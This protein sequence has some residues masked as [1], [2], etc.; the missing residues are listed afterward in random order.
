[1]TQRRILVTAALPYA[2]GDI[3]IGHLVEYIQTDIWV[4]FQ[5]LRG[6]AC[7]FFCADDTHGTAIMIR[8]RQEGRS[9]ETLIADVQQKHIADFAGF[10][11]EFDH[12]GSTNS[13]QN[14]KLCYEIWEALRKADLVVEKEV[15]QLFDVQENT[16]LA[17]RFVK[18]TCPKCKAPDQYGDN[19]D[20]CGST[21][22]PADLA[23]PISTLSNTTPE[24]RTASHLFVRIEDLHGFLDEWTQSG[25]HL[26]S[27]VANYLKGHFLGDPLRDW[28]ISRPAPYFGFEI[29]DSPGNYWYVWFDAP[30]G[31]IASTLEWC[32]NN[33]EDFDQWWKN[34]ETEVHHF[35][36]KDITYF[37]TLF[38]PAM[39]KTAGF[40][41]PEKVHI[42]GFL[43]VDGEKMSK[44]KG[45]FVKASTYLNHLDPACLR[46][47]YASKLGPRLD[48]LDLNLD[49][50]IQ[51]V[52]SDLVG[53]VVNLASRSA[54]FV[55]NTGL[56]AAYP[57]DGGL[58]AHAASRSDAIAA[59][60]EA[61]DYNG[62]MR[63]IL[64]L[65]DRANK[66]V[67]DQKPWELRQDESRQAEL[68]NICSISLNLFRQIVIYLSPVLPKLSELTGELL[69][70][71]IT[72]WDQAQTPLAGTAVNKFQH[73]FKRIEEKQVQAMTEEAREEVEA[74]ESEAAASQWN[75][76]GA[77][78][79]QEPMS[80]E[81][82]IDDFVKVDLRVARIVE[83][84]SV[85]EADKLL[86]LTLSLGGDERRNVF[87]G[88]KSA[89]DPEELVG[90][91]VIC[92]ANLKPRKMRF[93]T[94]EGMV[95]ASGPGGKDVF[96][97]SPDEGAVP[98]QRVH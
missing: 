80:E 67:E 33:G 41:L 57:E 45:T 81:C 77:A 14:R 95:L 46:Y 72:N 96:L 69:N 23:D 55:A 65:A 51:K 3:H 53:K 48:D 10:N 73:M 54:K 97:L 24:L 36:G 44:S 30:I 76:S 17:D 7:R 49:E 91:L 9:E 93:G 68:Q 79:E 56:S 59:A 16:F 47:Y 85:P 82:T 12:Y 35:I 6:H 74:A 38:W 40:N 62:A 4:R 61:C 37:H 66:Y 58:F 15:T 43:T 70:D 2:N 84:N 29:P 5:K 32:E 27:E 1:M 63:E 87:A 13:E 60:Y 25:A 98:G 89:Y 50:F 52:N 86:Q 75:D 88:I 26:Q 20:K 90:R 8:A 64:A 39:L 92:C 21:Y 78:L 18:G 31:Y 42:H 71:P 11:I 83:A 94:S 22:T 34:P 19:C 28:D